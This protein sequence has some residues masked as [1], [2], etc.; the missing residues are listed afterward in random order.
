MLPSN[1]DDIHIATLTVA[2][3]LAFA[4]STYVTSSKPDLKLMDLLQLV[5]KHGVTIVQRRPSSWPLS[6]MGGGRVCDVVA[7]L[8]CL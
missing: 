7:V 5:A 1:T 3:A 8:S 6:W 4:L 2:Q